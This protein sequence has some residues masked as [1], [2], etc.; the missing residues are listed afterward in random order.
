MLIAIRTI[1][2]EARYL[3]TLLTLFIVQPSYCL[4]LDICIELRKHHIHLVKKLILQ[5]E[6]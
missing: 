5:I 6:H 3:G 4:K 1:F 2:S